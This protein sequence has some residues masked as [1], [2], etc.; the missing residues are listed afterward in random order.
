RRVV[1]A[2]FIDGIDYATFCAT[3]SQEEKNAAGRTIWRF[4]FRALYRHGILYA[5]PHPGHYLFLGGGRVAFLDFGC[6]KQ[7]PTPLLEGMRRTLIAEQDGDWD[8]FLK[9]CIEVFGFDPADPEAF[10]IYV[11]Y[12]K[13]VTQ[14]PVLDRDFKFTH[15]Y[16]RETVAVLVRRGKKII[17]KP[18]EK[19]PHMPKPI[20]MPTDHTFVNRLQWG[21]Y[22]V[23]AGLGAEANWRRISEPWI[24]GRLAEP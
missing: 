10:D 13:L 6:S 17:F 11:E 8:E 20:H 16:A 21:L 5:D 2:E 4:M 7:L 22:S 24:R 9:A 23:L 15:E 12:T 18:D 19:M 14:P 1:T 3:A